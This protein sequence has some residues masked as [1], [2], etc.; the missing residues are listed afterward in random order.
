VLFDQRDC[1]SKVIKLNQS[2]LC[3]PYMTIMGFWMN[4]EIRIGDVSNNENFDYIISKHKLNLTK[5]KETKGKI[6]IYKNINN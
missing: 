3:D 2:S 6:F 1:G 4:D 5:I